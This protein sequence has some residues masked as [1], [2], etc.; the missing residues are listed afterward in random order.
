MS[1]PEFSSYT[2]TINGCID[3]GNGSGT[4]TGVTALQDCESVCQEWV[5][6]SSTSIYDSCIDK[7]AIPPGGG[8]LPDITEFAPGY[9]GPYPSGPW[10]AI[11]YFAD[12]TNGLQGQT[13]SD[14]KWECLGGCGWSTQDCDGPNG[15]WKYLKDINIFTQGA[16]GNTYNLLGAPYTDWVSLINGLNSNTMG[17]PFNLTMSHND[18]AQLLYGGIITG[19][20]APEKY[21]MAPGV[22][23]CEC[24]PSE[25]ECLLTGGTGH[26][27]GYNLNNQQGCEYVCCSGITI[28]ECSILITGQE[29]GV[30]YYDS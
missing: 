3:P 27:N 25:C 23:S 19:P 30:L 10:D 2:C 28:P 29:E 17:T 5:C 16:A 22:G 9:L 21:M 6:F 18:V 11:D 4:Y 15:A 24:I 20:A 26:T 1:H 13:F 12:T 14:Y 8:V 7:V